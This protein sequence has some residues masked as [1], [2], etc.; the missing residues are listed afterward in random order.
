MSMRFL[1]YY[2]ERGI[3]V[4]KKA[5]D[6][7]GTSCKLSTGWWMHEFFDKSFTTINDYQALSMEIRKRK[8]VQFAGGPL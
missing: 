2:R 7:L 5:I 6:M 1:D 3:N 4:I 8:S